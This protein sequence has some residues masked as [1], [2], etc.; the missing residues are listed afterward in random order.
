MKTFYI[1]IFTI[2]ITPVN[3]N[4]DFDSKKILK[5]WRHKQDLQAIKIKCIE[6]NLAK[7]ET[8]KND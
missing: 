8:T 7:Y 3:S 5:N 2:L 6:N 1:I 4:P